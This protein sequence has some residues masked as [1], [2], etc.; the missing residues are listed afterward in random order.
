[1]SCQHAP[2]WRA[3]PSNGGY[4]PAAASV[5][6]RDAAA[7]RSFYGRVLRGR[8]V[9]PTQRTLAEVGPWFLVEGTL[10][11]VRATREAD[12]PPITLRV[13]APEELAARCWDAGFDV[14]VHEG[15]SGTVALSVID[16]L[17]REIV[18]ACRESP[19]RARRT[20]AVHRR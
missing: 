14:R 7:V 9:W 6:D 18:L 17:G 20:L 19:V 2:D 8:R 1:L 5:G 12:Y 10:I 3:T 15:A 11:E 4:A 13:D 16:P